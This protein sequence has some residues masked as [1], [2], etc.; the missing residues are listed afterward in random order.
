MNCVACSAPCQNCTTSLNCTSC[1]HGYFLNKTSHKCLEIPILHCLTYK[2]GECVT[3]NPDSYLTNGSCKPCPDG[4]AKCPFGVCQICEA[5][6]YLNSQGQCQRCVMAEC[7]ICSEY[8][9]YS[10]QPGYAFFSSQCKICPSNCDSCQS[11]G[12]LTCLQCSKGYQTNWADP[13]NCQPCGLG[14]GVCT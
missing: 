5:G 11:N 1:Q 10:C 2:N 12:V 3:C 8:G 14:E 9:C 13:N 6:F 7:A 4:C